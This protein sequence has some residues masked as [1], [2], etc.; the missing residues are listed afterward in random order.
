MR[1]HRT[2]VGRGHQ[3]V[4]VGDGGPQ[5]AQAAAVAGGRHARQRRQFG[6]QQLG[7]RQHAR[8]R[9]APILAG[10]ADALQPAAQH[11]FALP[12]QPGHVAQRALL[13]GGAQRLD[14][15]DAQFG[16]QAGQR[17]GTDPRYL[18]E[19][20]HRRWKPFAQR[21]QLGNAPGVEEL[22]HLAGY[23]LADAVPL[24]Q[25]RFRNAREVFVTVAQPAHGAVVGARPERLWIL[26]V[27]NGQAPQLV[28]LRD[29]FV[30]L[31][32]RTHYPHIPQISMLAPP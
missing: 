23:R 15:L 19:L 26:I 2:W 13:D 11:L 14:A 31:Q 29:Q 6:D 32:R 25:L 4:Q 5:P 22:A 17:L 24:Q 1:H 12:A 16:A 8:D 21:L 28:E 10:G 18:S 3:D 27:E 30:H 9:L 20:L 7:L